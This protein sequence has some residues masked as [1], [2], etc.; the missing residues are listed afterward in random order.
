M[1]LEVHEWQVFRP[2][3]TSVDLSRPGETTAPFRQTCDISHGELL[4]LE[5]DLDQASS[6][7]V[8]KLL[9]G[10]Y[11]DFAVKRS[12]GTEVEAIKLNIETVQYL[13]GDIMLANFPV[14]PKGDY[15]AT[16]RVE[17]GAPALAGREQK[18]VAKY[19]LCGL[20]ELPVCL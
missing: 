10:L 14:V 13:D 5:C 3:E 20:E 8:A 16:L 7:N 1:N 11:A 9:D 19:A 6:Q 17:S 15:I 18:L 4:V 2:I 12:D